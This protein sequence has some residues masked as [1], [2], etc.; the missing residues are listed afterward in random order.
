MY[1]AL[2]LAVHF[3]VKGEFPLVA[4]GSRNLAV[5][6]SAMVHALKYD[7]TYLTTN[8]LSLID[9]DLLEFATLGIFVFAGL[10]VL[11]VTSAPVHERIAFIFF[12][13]QLGLLSGQ[14]W[15]ST[16]GEGRPLIEPYLMALVLL[17][18]TP[19]QYFSWRYL[20]P[21]IAC[22]VPALVVVAWHG[23]LYM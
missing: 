22:A 21:I 12:V 3:V 6:F 2:E 19:R 5:P 14:I 9:I 4:S 17:I 1:G 15:N 16:F 11:F 18:A 23:V 7:I 20:G 10:T 13:L 8:N